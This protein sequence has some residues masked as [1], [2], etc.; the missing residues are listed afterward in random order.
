MVLLLFST[1]VV[2]VVDVGVLFSH[3]QHTV[4]HGSGL[5]YLYINTHTSIDVCSSVRSHRQIYI[6]V[7]IY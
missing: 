1:A 2:I 7:I 6:I 4:V 5:H 3:F